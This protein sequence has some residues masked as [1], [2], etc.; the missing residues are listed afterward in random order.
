LLTKIATSDTKPLKWWKDNETLF[1]GLAAMARDILCISAAGTIVER[2]FC[3]SR[4]ICD[5]RR[6]QLEAKTIRSMMIVFYYQK[7]QHQQFLRQRLSKMIDIHDFSS[8]ELQQEYQYQIDSLMA[9][10]EIQYIPDIE[11]RPPYVADRTDRNAVRHTQLITRRQRMT[12][13]QQTTERILS[14]DP[15]TIAA[16]QQEYIQRDQRSRENDIYTMT[17]SSDEEDSAYHNGDYELPPLQPDRTLKRRREAEVY[18]RASQRVQR[19][20]S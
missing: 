14:R 6:N 5:Y 9:K 3:Y 15:I 19:Q 12:L 17:V 8:E 10:L 16:R 18:T 4:D 13:A 2:V 20:T 11:P 7:G 1:P